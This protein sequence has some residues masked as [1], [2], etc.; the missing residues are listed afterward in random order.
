MPSLRQR[1][2][3]GTRF[4]R[5][6]VVENPSVSKGRSKSKV[7]CDCGEIAVIN[8]NNLFSGSS[9]SCGCFTIER[10][11]NTQTKH[12]HAAGEKPSKTYL[13]WQQMRN[14]CS[15]PNSSNYHRYGGRGI[16]VCE[17]WQKFENFL[18]DMGE[19]PL[20]ASIDRIDVNGNYEP[21]NCRWADAVTQSR[22]RRDVRNI[23]V[24]DRTATLPEWATI[25]NVKYWTLYSRF[26]R[27]G[28]SVEKL[29]AY[30]RNV[31]PK[32]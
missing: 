6:T 20:N 3:I 22:N 5:W 12:F 24:G 23:T 25:L 4:G 31:C 1:P 11:R 28:F 18:T 27:F 19:K 21:G 17:R 7:K 32:R 14:R 8:C 26:R 15:N 29:Q 9:Q 2:N 30:V 16:T 10:S 13:T